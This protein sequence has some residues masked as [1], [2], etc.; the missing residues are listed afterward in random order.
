MSN[1][2]IERELTG[3]I[4]KETA[5]IM[6]EAEEP[7]KDFRS[8]EAWEYISTYLCGENDRK[9]CC[10]ILRGETQALARMGTF[11]IQVG[12]QGSKE[13]LSLLCN[14]EPN[15]GKEKLDNPGLKVFDS[16]NCLTIGKIPW[17]CGKG[18]HIFTI[19]QYPNRKFF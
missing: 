11:Q 3:S 2:H 18:I 19:L 10:H 4:L 17:T 15:A 16:G 9:S 14:I 1:Y 6:L 12:K 5:L 8:I 7:N 13:V